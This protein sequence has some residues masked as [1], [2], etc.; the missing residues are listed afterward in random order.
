MTRLL[1]FM[2]P[3][4][5]A[6]GTMTL[7]WAP[8]LA[9]RLWPAALLAALAAVVAH[10]FAAITRWL[11]LGQSLMGAIQAFSWTVAGPWA[12]LLACTAPFVLPRRR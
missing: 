2:V 6:V 5:L 10:R 4:A 9:A 7:W 1:W 12:A 3:T 8:G 11:G